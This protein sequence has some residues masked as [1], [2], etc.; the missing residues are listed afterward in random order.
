MFEARL[1]QGNLFK[2]I[3]EAIAPLVPEI[4]I[5]ITSSGLT[6]Q[7]M[8]SGHVCL[9][10]LELDAGT[11]DPFRCDKNITLGLQTQNLLK[12]L[13]CASNDD[14]ITLRA[15]HDTDSMEVFIENTDQDRMSSFEIKLMDID[16]ERLGIPDRENDAVIK[17][18]STDFQRITR[19]VTQFG[20]SMVITCTKEGIQ[21]ATA[22]SNT[23]SSAKITLK[24][25]ASMDKKGEGVSIELSEPVAQTFACHYLGF[26]I[27]ATPLS[28]RVTISVKDGQ[29]MCLEYPIGSVGH[30]QY[31][32]A[33]KV[34]D[35]I[36][37]CKE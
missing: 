36:D 30:L 27:K 16:Q 3:V 19:D 34:T 23:D 32:L 5:E 9:L 26:F 24:E 33:P 2:K 21:F 12:V 28:D 6:I 18:P 8:D 17:L 11:F 37:D 7:A 15:K 31:F 13:R 10:L 1:A 29:P 35:D 22:P 4:N 20:D 14:A 25:G